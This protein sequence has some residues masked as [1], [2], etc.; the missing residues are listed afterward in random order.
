MEGESSR[1]VDQLDVRTLAQLARIDPGCWDRY[2]I[3]VP[4]RKS[5]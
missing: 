5:I 3:A 4:K 2:D 1:K